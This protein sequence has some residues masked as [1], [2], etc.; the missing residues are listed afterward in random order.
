M[1]QSIN[2]QVGASSDD[3]CE[4]TEYYIGY[5]T[6]G[7]SI[8]CGKGSWSRYHLGV[9]FTSIGIPQGAVINSAFLS[10]KSSQD[11]P[12]TPDFNL[13]IYGDDVDDAPIF[14][15]THKVLSGRTPTSAVVVWNDPDAWTKDAWHDTPD[16]KTIIQELADA[17]YI[18]GNKALVLIIKDIGCGTDNYHSVY[19]WDTDPASAPKLSIEYSIE[20]AQSYAF[21]M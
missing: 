8:I 4:K 21:I 13:Q 2:K 11:R 6:T 5:T 18:S 20:G 19:S 16:L 12:E 14:D 15:A 10:F 1:T 17:G 7:T 3:A 9:R